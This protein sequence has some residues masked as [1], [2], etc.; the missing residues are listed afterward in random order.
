[1]LCAAALDG[2]ARATYKQCALATLHQVR[3]W[4]MCH[5]CVCLGSRLARLHATCCAVLQVGLHTLCPGT[6]RDSVS[7][8]PH[9]PALQHNNLAYLC[10]AIEGSKELRAVGE[11]WLER[12][13]VG[14]AGCWVYCVWKRWRVGRQA[15]RQPG[16]STSASPDCAHCAER[17]LG[18]P[19]SCLQGQVEQQRQAFVEAAWGPLLALLRQDAR[20]PVPANLAGDKAA[21]QGIKDKWTAVNKAMGEAQAQQVRLGAAGWWASRVAGGWSLHSHNSK[22]CVPLVPTGH[23]VQGWA[24]P[25]AGLRFALKDAVAEAS[26]ACGAAGAH[27]PLVEPAVDQTTLTA[28]L[29]VQLPPAAGAHPPLLI[30]ILLPQLP[31]GAAARLRGLLCQ[32][33]RQAVHLR[34]PQARALQPG[35][36]AGTGGRLV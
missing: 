22:Q 11:A 34:P 33:R 24:V 9:L 29:P 25:D 16:W 12:H 27:P 15:G 31:P 28:P 6:C 21:R 18:E 19:P 20:Q 30:V 3:A 17:T 4:L 2:K 8:T 32:V 5:C 10:H 7:S 23:H 1:M 26:G 13:Q 35:R 14:A 36:C